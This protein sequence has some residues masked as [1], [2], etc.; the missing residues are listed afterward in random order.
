MSLD[1][2]TFLV[3]TDESSSEALVRSALPGSSPVRVV[4]VDDALGAGEQLIAEA[5]PDMVIVGCSTHPEQALRLIA[6]L[7]V[8][9]AS[10]PIVALYDGNPNG[11]MGPAF[12]AGADD[13]ITLPQSTDQL[14]FALEKVAAR[15]H[16][17][18]AHDP[19]GAHR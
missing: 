11:F 9:S 15:R 4:L 6:E 8:I 17:P 12:R 7:S 18:G 14:R 1:G 2:F 10:R 5:A 16:T 3:V 13:L 19:A